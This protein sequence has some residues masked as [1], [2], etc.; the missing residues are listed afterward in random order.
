MALGAPLP[1][2]Q[3]NRKSL[4]A[5]ANELSGRDIRD[6]AAPIEPL[7]AREVDILRFVSRNMLNKEI[8]DRMGLTEG[9]VKWYMQ[10]I[11]DKLGVRR[12]LGALEKART[13]G[14]VN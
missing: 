10:Q 2:S 8:G 7:T 1:N 9:S 14:Y 13:L 3:P 4:A 6:S 11:Y 12:R 5:S